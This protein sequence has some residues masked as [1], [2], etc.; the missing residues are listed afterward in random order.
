[1]AQ[2][3]EASIE[4]YA[5]PEIAIPANGFVKLTAPD[6]IYVHSNTAT[7]CQDVIN[8]VPCQVSVSV[9]SFTITTSIALRANN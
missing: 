5:V 4:F 7:V 6:E 9:K 2:T 3:S 8:N 1:M